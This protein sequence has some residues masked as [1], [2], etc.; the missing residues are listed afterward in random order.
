LKLLSID[1]SSNICGVSILEDTKLICNLDINTKRT[2]SENLMPM[3][4]KAFKE[5][6]LSL[7]DIDLMV[8]DIGPRLFYWFTNWNCNS[9]SI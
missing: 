9:K 1:T 7:Q 5:S 4:D 2:H 6:N 8:C 3:I